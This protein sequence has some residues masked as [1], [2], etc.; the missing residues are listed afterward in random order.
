MNIQNIREIKNALIQRKQRG[1][2]K[3]TRDQN[4]SSSML[5][6]KG[7]SKGELNSVKQALGGVDNLIDQNCKDKTIVGD[8]SKYLRE[9][10]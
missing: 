4:I 2:F 8:W 6:K 5:H 9:E 3:E 1:T 7:M 10:R